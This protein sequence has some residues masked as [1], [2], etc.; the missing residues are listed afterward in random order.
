MW[1]SGGTGQKY[2]GLE[3]PFCMGV[4]TNIAVGITRSMHVELS[5]CILVVTAGKYLGCDNCSMR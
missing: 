2:M 4:T 3:M 5:T 1:I